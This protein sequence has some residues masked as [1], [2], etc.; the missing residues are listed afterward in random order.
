MPRF[1]LLV[2]FF[3]LIRQVSGQSSRI[4]S[5]IQVI[6]A[7]PDTT[8]QAKSV[9]VNEYQ[10]LNRGELLREVKR[11]TSLLNTL[12]GKAKVV[13]YGIVG[14]ECWGEQ[15]F[16]E[17]LS[18]YNESIDAAIEGNYLFDAAQGHL[19]L[20]DRFMSS[21]MYAEALERAYKAR[22]LFHSINNLYW[23]ARTHS[24]AGTIAYRAGNYNLCAEEIS[25]SLAI[26]R[27]L[28]HSHFTR[29][30][31]TELMSTYNTSGLTYAQL[32][33]YK[34]A[35]AS[36]A[37]AEQ[38]AIATNNTFWVG[39]I[40]GNKSDI[41]YAQGQYDKAIQALKFDFYESINQREWSSAIVAALHLSRVSMKKEDWN[42][43][44]HFLDTAKILM[45]NHPTL[46]KSAR[47]SYWEGIAS[48]QAHRGNHKAAYDA[49]LIFKALHDSIDVERQA[50]NLARITTA[51]EIQLKQAQIE[52]LTA[53]NKLR[54]Q[55]VFNRNVVVASILGGVFLL[56]GWLLTMYRSVQTK[57]KDN[58]L[59]AEQNDEI[60]TMNEELKSYSETLAQQNLTIQKMNEDLEFQVDRR[61]HE[62]QEAN[63]E[64]DTFLYRASHDIRRPITSLLGLAHLSRFANTDAERNELFEKVVNTAATMDNMLT[65]MQK[66][67][68]L[69]HPGTDR[70]QISIKQAVLNAFAKFAKFLEKSGM[71]H[72]LRMDN[73]LSFEADENL[74]NVILHNLIENAIV[75]R[76]VAGPEKPQIW[77]D[78]E[79]LGNKVV[80]KC[81]DN[82][83]GIENKYL[84]NIFESH[85]RGTELSTGI[86]LGLYLVKRAV[87]ALRGHIEVLSEYGVSTT[88][89]VY[90]PIS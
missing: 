47:A 15:L 89:I 1:V 50:M 90:L 6:A 76:K 78:V 5:L 27:L 18:F 57:K 65:K 69:N 46:S 59:L 41:Y 83:I 56:L 39:L 4:D 70:Y 72:S 35:M 67:Y 71:S 29:G 20:A 73:S 51:H 10:R 23:E 68:E 85:F 74:L 7:E 60:N 33:D 49:L 66:V 21:E 42:D 45:T 2:F 24:V 9:L 55:Q 12:E 81:R 37:A 25:K 62:L 17:A 64:L 75:F 26:Y 36:F 34:K 11:A 13:L 32:K 14:A 52:L 19:S 22:E 61:T 88:F 63:A 82:G 79:Q 53:E 40:N 80:I 58:K 31:S 38:I 16:T 87:S 43:A 3:L 28:D 84:D 48:L 44:T 54:S 86:G 30:D 8:T 77:I